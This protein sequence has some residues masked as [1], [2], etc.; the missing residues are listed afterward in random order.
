MRAMKATWL[1]ALLLAAGL[2][3]G[4]ARA[5]P[6]TDLPALGPEAAPDRTQVK[7][8]EIPLEQ[9]TNDER[10]TVN[11]QDVIL[12]NG[13]RRFG[14]RKV[15]TLQKP[16]TVFSHHVGWNAPDQANWY[17]SNMFDL[18]INGKSVN[19]GA[20]TFTILESGPRGV[21]DFTITNEMGQFRCRFVVIPNSEV[22]FAEFSVEP[23]VEVQSLALRLHNYPGGFAVPREGNRERRVLIVEGTLD[24]QP[25][26]AELDAQYNWWFFYH[27]AFLD[28]AI[29]ENRA[30]AYG[31]SALVLPRGQ[32]QRI[33]INVG[34]YEVPT[35]LE[36]PPT[37]RRFR[38]AFLD[39]YEVA[40]QVA[41]TR[42]AQERDAIR[43]TLENL[44]FV[45]QRLREAQARLPEIKAEGLPAPVAS[46]VP[47][48]RQL[49]AAL[50][51]GDPWPQ[52]PVT[53]EDRAR[54]LLDQ[55]D[56]A[57][58]Q[59]VKKERPGIGVL[60]LRGLHSRY[61]GLE[62][63]EKLLGRR[64]RESEVSYYAEYY[65]K[66]EEITYFPATWEDLSRFD[67]IVFAN[68]PFSVLG[69]QRAQALAE[70]LQAGGAVLLLGG[71]HAFGQAGMDEGPLGPLM[72]VRPR[73][74]FD[75]QRFAA[76]WP[77]ERT[78]QAPPW[79]GTGGIDWERPPVTLWY[80][81]VDAAPGS[82]V[83]LEA[84]GQP[85]L[86]TGSV[87]AGRVAAVCAP[88]YGEV[89]EGDRVF[90]EWES[91][92]ALMGRL[93]LWLGRGDTPPDLGK[94]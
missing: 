14:L 58:W 45:P 53:A 38:M 18:E 80:H 52:Q 86:V 30:K 16:A 84:D 35:L 68:V 56:K 12:D 88:P 24:E 81:Q 10:R 40:N 25:R 23:A 64:C 34:D 44:I 17:H 93:L 32:A 11:T 36:Y 9:V 39:Y 77:V 75:L 94:P 15:E 28:K 70:Y 71:T 63:A 74:L 91:W 1:P 22:L 43:E 26:P 33:T 6:A 87:G 42:F 50:P 82:T 47:E 76:Y 83:W 4:P 55:Y 49:L 3:V 20:S 41:Q 54:Q 67:V 27:D 57:R 79:L 69:S 51:A 78:R 59:V 72:P 7:V 29:P 5:Q 37:T 73:G 21:A 60:T 13:V 61:W 65:W 46:G 85:F 31:P 92:P 89:G 2:G 62:E 48:L 66:G 19:Y 90:W 8:S